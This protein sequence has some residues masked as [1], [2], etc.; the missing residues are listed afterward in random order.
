M[1][2]LLCLFLLRVEGDHIVL[3]GLHV[4]SP[5]DLAREAAYKIYYWHNPEQEHLLKELLSQRHHLAQLCDYQT[6][7]HRS[8]RTI[9]L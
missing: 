5:N 9:K 7:A 1:S 4:D 6:F 8:A 2:N 3:N